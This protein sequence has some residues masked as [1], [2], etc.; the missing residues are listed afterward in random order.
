MRLFIAINFNNDFKNAVSEIYRKLNKS[1]VKGN[2]TLLDN[3]HLTLAFLGET[4]K[5][6]EIKKVIDNVKFAPFTLEFEKINSF[7]SGAKNIVYL[8][9]KSDS[10]NALATDLR[11]KLKNKSVKFDE[12]DFKAHITLIREAS[13]L[14]PQNFSIDKLKTY[15]DKIDLMHSQRIDG[16][17][18]YTKIY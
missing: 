14:P 1:G 13:N 7:K 16:A 6:D 10:L 8:E 4:N 9:T 11:T 2:F 5:V 17:L 18:T 12:K 15:A 3:L